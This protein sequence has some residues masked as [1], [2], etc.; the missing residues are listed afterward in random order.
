MLLVLKLL[1]TFYVIK[2]LFKMDIFFQ[3]ITEFHTSYLGLHD[4]MLNF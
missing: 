2:A 1:K 4:I 3:K